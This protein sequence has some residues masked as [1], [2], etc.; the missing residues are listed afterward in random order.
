MAIKLLNK[1]VSA[2]NTAT[3]LTTLNIS[4]SFFVIQ[5]DK[6]NLDRVYF[7]DANTSSTSDQGIILSVTTGA[8]FPSTQAINGIGPN[9]INLNGVYISSA[10]STARVNVLYQEE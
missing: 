5:A 7:G 2:A 9:G 1:T 3:V 6:D 10:S 8:A 4:C